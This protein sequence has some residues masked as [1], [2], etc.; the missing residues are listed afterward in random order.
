MENIIKIYKKNKEIINYIIFGGFTTLVNFIVYFSFTNLL[1]IHYLIANII[2]WIAAVLF[3][4]VTNRL[5]VFEKVNIGFKL[6]FREMCLFFMS[7]LISGV[8]ETAILFC[9]IDLFNFGENIS[10]VVVAFVVVILNYI[11]S[12]VLVFKKY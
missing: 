5:Y 12:K 10:K 2:A 7:R 8:A 9:M 1:N 6:V 4:Y 3:A 11:F